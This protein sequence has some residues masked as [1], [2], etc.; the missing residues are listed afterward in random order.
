[1]ASL[2]FGRVLMR[3]P[4]LPLNTS[5]GPAYNVLRKWSSRSSDVTGNSN[6]TNSLGGMSSK[7]QVFQE[8]DAEIILDIYE[9][10]LKYSDLLEEH[11]DTDPF[12]GINLHRKS[13]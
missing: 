10:K 8:E 7:Y 5:K 12:E 13:L 1:M 3:L 11:E 9:E 4:K 6:K 2:H